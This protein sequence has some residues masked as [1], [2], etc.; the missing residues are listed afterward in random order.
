ML[1]G[2]AAVAI[3]AYAVCSL[4]RRRRRQQIP[5]GEGAY[6]KAQ[7]DGALRKPK[8]A[9]SNEIKEIEGENVQPVEMDAGYVGAEIETERSNHGGIGRAE[10]GHERRL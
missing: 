9:G 5:D 1:V 4:L 7:L 2:V 10:L 6:E 3:L 8:E